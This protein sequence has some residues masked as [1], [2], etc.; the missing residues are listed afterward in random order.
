MVVVPAISRGVFGFAIP[1]HPS[2]WDAPL[3]V[4]LH[5]QYTLVEVVAAGSGAGRPLH[6]DAME[7]DKVLVH[8]HAADDSADGAGDWVYS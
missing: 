4:G 8:R 2:C 6:G 3:R 1:L 7:P 5:G